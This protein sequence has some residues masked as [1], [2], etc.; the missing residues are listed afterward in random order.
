[1]MMLGGATVLTCALLSICTVALAQ[2]PSAIEAGEQLYN[3]YCASCHGEKLRAVGS[4]SDLRTLPADA[5]P[6]FD[7]AVLNGKGQM[8]PWRGVLNEPELDQ[9]WAYIRSRAR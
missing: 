4:A 1:M 8:P 6:R 5:R 7:Q 9:L 2:D 3:Q